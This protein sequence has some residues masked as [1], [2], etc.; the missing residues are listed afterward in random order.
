M[1]FSTC[2]ARAL[3]LITH[4]RHAAL[5]WIQNSGLPGLGGDAMGIGL[6][7]EA[8]SYW[9]VQLTF[10]HYSQALSSHPWQHWQSL[11]GRS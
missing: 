11:C 1:S 6:Q 10:S 2:T 4:A 9:L 3:A 8:H 7:L 5:V